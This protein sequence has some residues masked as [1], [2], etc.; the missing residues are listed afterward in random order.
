M[1]CGVQNIFEVLVLSHKA[2]R[3]KLL[4]SHHIELSKRSKHQHLL[5]QWA[6]HLAVHQG[7]NSSISNEDNPQ[8]TDPVRIIATIILQLSFL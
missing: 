7:H 6:F 8:I 3:T 2:W 1:L 5:P 4:S